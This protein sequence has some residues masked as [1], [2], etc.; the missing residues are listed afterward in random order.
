M[1]NNRKAT[2]VQQQI[3]REQLHVLLLLLM[4]FMAVREPTGAL[5]PPT[6]WSVA[7]EKTYLLIQFLE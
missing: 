4:V 7:V 5:P 1:E 6:G 3:F 2:A